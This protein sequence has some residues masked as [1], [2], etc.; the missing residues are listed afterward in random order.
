MT[1]VGWL[2]AIVFFLL[3]LAIT[4]PLGTYMAR[5]FQGERTWLT[6]ALAP[7]EKLIYRLCGVDEGE[8]MTWYAYSLSMLA[9]SL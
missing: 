4:K 3:I 7:I 2:Q 8:E 9:F 6:P 5:V 1:A